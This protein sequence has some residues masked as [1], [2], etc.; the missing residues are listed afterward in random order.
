MSTETPHNPNAG[1]TASALAMLGATAL[2]GILGLRVVS[3]MPVV[4]G[5][6]AA[7]YALLRA[8]RQP[9]GPS[10]QEPP[11][12][13]PAHQPD[14]FVLEWLERQ[15]QADAA[16]PSVELPAQDDT[17]DAAEPPD[18]Y[19]PL[20]LL[21]DDETPPPAGLHES[22]AELTEPVP[23]SAATTSD[24]P[25]TA[26]PF[27]P[28]FPAPSGLDFEPMPALSE[29]AETP[30]TPLAPANPPPESTF[31]ANRFVF[32]GGNF[33]DHI[34]VGQPN[35]ESD[36]VQANDPVQSADTEPAPV[37]HS[38]SSANV[39]EITVELASPGEASFDP[40]L[41][42]LPASTWP[43]SDPESAPAS[44]PAPVIADGQF[45]LRPQAHV[46]NSI[47]PKAPN[48][49]P[50]NARPAPFVDASNPPKTPPDPES[51]KDK[52]PPKSDWNS[53]WRGD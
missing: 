20:S 24:Q 29:K 38:E 25:A 15:S 19:V 11:P 18:N 51:L 41:A 4:L 34:E 48:S 36:P 9:P 47:L 13:A 39:P 37:A 6:G 7:A 10:P 5:A 2:G 50:W 22:Y 46:Q 44:D 16:A 30:F 53:W 43:P 42:G 21:P 31:V 3:K 49:S 14:A 28:A 52:K 26:A 33:P 27:I 35:A 8:R 17:P 23:P 40:P 12:P 45:V 1:S 32:E